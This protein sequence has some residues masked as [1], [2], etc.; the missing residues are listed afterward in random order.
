MVEECPFCTK[1]IGSE[2]QFSLP[3]HV[4]QEHPVVNN[5]QQRDEQSG[6]HHRN[7][8]MLILDDGY[9]WRCILCRGAY[10]AAVDADKLACAGPCK[11]CVF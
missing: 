5:W 11:C 6:R 7:G 9:E 8:H 10:G 2:N 4:Q 3:K 1:K